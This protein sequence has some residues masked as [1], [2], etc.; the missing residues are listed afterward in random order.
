M[1]PFVDMYIAVWLCSHVATFWLHCGYM[2]MW[3]SGYVATCGYVAVWHWPRGYV[4]V[5]NFVR[6]P[7]PV[8]AY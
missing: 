5:L 6:I 8:D 2:A 1:E 4:A 7:R 3:L